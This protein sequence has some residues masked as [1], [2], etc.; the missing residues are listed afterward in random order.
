MDTIDK[1]E[2]VA[3]DGNDRPTTDVKILK[4]TVVE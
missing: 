4:M 3:T 2:K 1:I